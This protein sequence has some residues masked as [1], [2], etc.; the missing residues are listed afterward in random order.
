MDKKEQELHEK[1]NRM[2]LKKIGIDL[3]ELRADNSERGKRTKGFMQG[4]IHEYTKNLRKFEDPKTRNYFNNFIATFMLE[5]RQAFE[6]CRISVPYRI[7]S[8]KSTFDKILEYLGR[9]DKSE[10]VINE[11]GEPER[12]LKEE[13][14]DMF[15]ITVV[16]TS[17]PPLFSYSKDPEIKKLIEEQ[18][19]NYALLE[20]MQNFQ[21]QITDDIFSGKRKKTYNYSCSREEYYL[22]AMI[23]INRIKT[24]IHPNATELL[25]KYDELLEKIKQNVPEEFYRVANSA[26]KDQEISESLETAEH[27]DLARK[28]TRRFIDKSKITEDEM[29]ILEEK[30]TAGDVSVVDFGSI[31]DDFTARIHDKL[32]LA[33]LTKQIKSIFGNSRLLNRFGVKISE[34]NIKEKRTENGYVSNFLYLDTPFG[35]IEMQLQSEHENREGNYG[36]SAHFDMEGKGFKEFP[37]PKEGKVDDLDRFRKCVEFVSPQKYTATYDRSEQDRVLIQVLGKYQ[38]Y[39]NILSQIKKGTI[40]DLKLQKYLEK[41]YFNKNVIFE[42][43]AEQE[44]LECFTYFDINRYLRTQEFKEIEARWLR[45]QAE[46]N[47]AKNGETS[48]GEDAEQK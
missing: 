4:L 30:F 31:L 6:N 27:V 10:W 2:L 9:D 37:I 1:K 48:F 26:A 40:R 38:N 39:K 36:Y 41:L 47:K 35:R 20:E 33:V 34:A 44:Q 46:R 11:Q 24:L 22:N 28:L 12:R 25:K 19:R 21:N 5:F 3:D 17:R 43:E 23:L 13:I 42:G 7:K 8:P 15:A 45:E 18:K 14:K 29:K 32:D 16:A